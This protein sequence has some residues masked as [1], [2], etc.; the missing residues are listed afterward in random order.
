MLTVEMNSSRQQQVSLSTVKSR[1][2]SAE[3]TECIDIINPLLHKVNK[4]NGENWQNVLL[5][6][7]C[8][9]EIFGSRISVFKSGER[10]INIWFQQHGG[11]SVMM[12]AVLRGKIG[13]DLIPVMEIMKKEQEHSIFQKHAI[14]SGLHITGQNSNFKRQ[15]LNPFF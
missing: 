7:D 5:P 10:I 8:K 11:E 12:S 15:R 1:L 13:R 4:Q 3:I 9:F 6:N 14:L 2:R